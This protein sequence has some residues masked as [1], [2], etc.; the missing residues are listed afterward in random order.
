MAPDPARKAT[1]D[2]GFT[3][4]TA[5]WLRLPATRVVVSFSDPA[6][7][8]RGFHSLFPPHYTNLDQ[9]VYRASFSFLLSRHLRPRMASPNKAAHLC[10]FVANPVIGFQNFSVGRICIAHVVPRAILAEPSPLLG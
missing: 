6:D 10:C 5:Q 8:G 3:M 9:C 7:P 2:T 1:V 4:V